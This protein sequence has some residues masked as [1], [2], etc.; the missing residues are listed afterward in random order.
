VLR[1]PITAGGAPAGKSERTGPSPSRR[2][3]CTDP[4]RIERSARRHKQAAVAITAEADIGTTLRQVDAPDRGPG[5]IEDRLALQ[6][7]RVLS[8]ELILCNDLEL[9]FASQEARAEWRAGAIK[10]RCL[11][12]R[13]LDISSAR[14]GM[15][16]SKTA[17]RTI[18]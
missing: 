11:N 4:H 5:L 3:G 10:L 12:V 1:R 8:A 6:T 18:T 2:P 15:N 7:K 14:A 17:E 9:E 13:P 16:A